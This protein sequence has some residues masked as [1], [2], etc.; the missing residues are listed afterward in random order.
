MR[1]RGKNGCQRFDGP[2]PCT[3]RIQLI[4]RVAR[5]AWFSR[6]RPIAPVSSARQGTGVGT[7]HDQQNVFSKNN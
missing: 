1:G 3:P 6:V 4:N 2:H 5:D 7:F